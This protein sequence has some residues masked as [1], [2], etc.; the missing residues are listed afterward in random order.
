MLT[1]ELTLYPGGTWEALENMQVTTKENKTKIVLFL[2]KKNVFPHWILLKNKQLEC[3]LLLSLGPNQNFRTKTIGSDL[4]LQ[5]KFSQRKV[6][7]I[8]QQFIQ[9]NQLENKLF[10]SFVV[11]FSWLMLMSMS[12]FYLANRKGPWCPLLWKFLIP[13][14]LELYTLFKRFEFFAQYYVNQDFATLSGLIRHNLALDK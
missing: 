4:T 12:Y 1:L 11:Y 9:A 6:P 14:V 2:A 13:C 10:W 8:S 7:S 3:A 5:F